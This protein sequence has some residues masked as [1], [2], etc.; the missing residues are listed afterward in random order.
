M[1]NFSYNKEKIINNGFRIV[2]I[3]NTIIAQKPRM[4]DHIE[5]M[6]LNISKILSYCF[7][8]VKGDIAI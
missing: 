7:L 6:K 3:D 5:E 8:N 1:F 4:S 2:H